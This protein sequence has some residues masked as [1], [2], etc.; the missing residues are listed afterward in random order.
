MAANIRKSPSPD[1]RPQM[2]CGR[3]WK[4]VLEVAR[5][6]AGTSKEVVSRGVV[7]GRVL[8]PSP[9]QLLAVQMGFAHLE[10]GRTLNGDPDPV[11][12]WSHGHWAVGPESVFGLFDWLD[13]QGIQLDGELL[14]LARELAGS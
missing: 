14:A 13:F 9:G 5:E 8:R 12:C 11:D 7:N 6:A 3:G 4:E 2:W 1:G 10:A